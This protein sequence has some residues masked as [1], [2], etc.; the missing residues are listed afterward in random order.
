MLINEIGDA[1]IKETICP[2]PKCYSILTNNMETKST[3]K[4]ISTRKQ[5]LLTHEKYKE[6][7]QQKVAVVQVHIKNLTTLKKRIF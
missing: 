4:E 1:D 2:Q 7:H 6:I 5:H 3:A